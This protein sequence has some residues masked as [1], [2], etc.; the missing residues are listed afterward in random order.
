MKPLVRNLLQC[1]HFVACT[2]VDVMVCSGLRE[3]EEEK[4]RSPACR[5]QEN[6]TFSSHYQNLGSTF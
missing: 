5:G 4:L 6:A 2:G 3:Y 1:E